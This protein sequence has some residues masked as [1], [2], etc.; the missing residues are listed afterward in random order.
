MVFLFTHDQSKMC[1]KEL[2][3]HPVYINTH[4]GHVL[5]TDHVFVRFDFFGVPC[6][7]DSSP[8]TARLWLQDIGFVL[9]LSCIG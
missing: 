9:L 1:D 2:T 7:P 3:R 4:F 6:D 8:L 5:L